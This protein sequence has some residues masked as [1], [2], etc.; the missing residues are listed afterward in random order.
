MSWNYRVLVKR[1]EGYTNIDA[2]QYGIHE[3][4]YVDNGIP[5]SCTETACDPDGET[6]EELRDSM[7]QMMGAQVNPIME[8][9]DIGEEFSTT[10]NYDSSYSAGNESSSTGRWSGRGPQGIRG[11]VDE[12]VPT[13]KWGFYPPGWESRE[14]ER[15]ANKEAEEVDD[16]PYTF[17]KLKDSSNP[18]EQ[19]VRE[20]Y[21]SSYLDHYALKKILEAL[22]DP[23]A[24]QAMEDWDGSL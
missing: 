9:E 24:A 20:L 1:T 22:E 17:G 6:V 19:V 21:R 16:S 14:E 5:H 23:D 2:Q 13:A 11:P 3:V 10:G 15:Y 18:L 7:I 4:Y 8:Y 12:S